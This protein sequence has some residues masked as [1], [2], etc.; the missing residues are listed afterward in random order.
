MM[1]ALPAVLE[2]AKVMVPAPTSLSIAALPAVLLPAKIMAPPL[3]FSKFA[4][5]AVLVPKKLIAPPLFADTDRIIVARA[6]TAYE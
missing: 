6:A 4:L 3:S 1:L 5:P 2:S